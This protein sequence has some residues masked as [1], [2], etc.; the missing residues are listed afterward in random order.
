MAHPVVAIVKRDSGWFV[1]SC[2]GLHGPF[3]SQYDALKTA[4]ESAYSVASLAGSADVRLLGNGG[5]VPLCTLVSPA[6]SF[7]FDSVI[8]ALIVVAVATFLVALW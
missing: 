1:D 7:S 8:V 3:E 6:R 2:D 5:V 4:L